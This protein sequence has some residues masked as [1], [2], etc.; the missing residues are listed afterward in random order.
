M[1]ISESLEQG[2]DY[3]T[4]VIESCDTKEQ[5]DGAFNLVENY[6]KIHGETAMRNYLFLQ[7]RIMNRQLQLNY[8]SGDS[9]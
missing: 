8:A 9:K 4:T 2:Y 1:P 7:N 5:L 3:C 6:L